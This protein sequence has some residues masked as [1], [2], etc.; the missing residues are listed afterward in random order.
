MQSK[1]SHLAQAVRF[2]IAGA[3]GVIAYCLLRGTVLPYRISG[4]L[5]RCFGSNQVH[6]K[7]R[8]VI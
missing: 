2:C 3:A 1:L 5:V 6:P 7:Q 4:S 8:S